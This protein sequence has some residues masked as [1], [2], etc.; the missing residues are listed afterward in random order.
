M[1]N[2]W[3]GYNIIEIRTK[4]DLR[5]SDTTYKTENVKW[6]KNSNKKKARFYKISETKS[7]IVK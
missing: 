3:L 1:E 6:V 2:L 5:I 4:G 7:G